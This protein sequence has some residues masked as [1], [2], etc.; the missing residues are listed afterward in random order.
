[1]ITHEIERKCLK[2]NMNENKIK[3]PFD[4]ISLEHHCAN[5]FDEL[6]YTQ[7]DEIV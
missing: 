3:T 2:F 6:C 7:P 1:M 4:T 5:Q